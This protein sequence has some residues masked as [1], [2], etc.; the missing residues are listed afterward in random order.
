MPTSVAHP[1]PVRFH[2][3]LH[4]PLQYGASGG[5]YYLQQTMVDWC[6]GVG[7]AADRSGARISFRREP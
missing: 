2:R 6:I 1:H 3:P 5:L 4:D 7:W